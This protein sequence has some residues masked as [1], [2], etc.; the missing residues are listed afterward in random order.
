[1]S[2]EA[3]LW[4]A[5]EAPTLE[6]TY[7]AAHLAEHHLVQVVCQVML[8]LAP[9]PGMQAAV[10]SVGLDVRSEMSPTCPQADQKLKS[11]ELIQCAELRIWETLA[12]PTN[13]T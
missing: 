7:P 6:S 1:M 8:A 3:Q 13:E 9:A 10:A 11:Q 5:Q 12:L 2:N 4:A